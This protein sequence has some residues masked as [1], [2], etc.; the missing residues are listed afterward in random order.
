MQPLRLARTALRS[1]L[2]APYRPDRAV[3]ALGA[4]RSWGSTLAGAAAAAAALHPND[5]AVV[6]D[7]QATTFAELHDRTNALAH[8]LANRGVR[9]G[10]TV[11]V[12]AHNGHAFVETCIAISKLGADALLLNT[13]MAGP[14]LAAVCV[15]EQ[16]VALVHDDDFAELVDLHLAELVPLRIASGTI[17]R[18]VRA[19]TTAGLTPPERP[20]RTI[21][22]TSG[23]TGV[24]KGAARSGPPVSAGS[25]GLLDAVPYRRGE[26]MLVAAPLFHA[27]GFAHLSIGLAIG[28]PVVLQPRF[29]PAA[30][31]TEIARRRVGVLVAVPV[32]LRR[33]LDVDPDIAAPLDVSCLRLVPLSGSAIPAGLAEEFMDRFGEVVYNLYG[34][35]EVGSATVASPADLRAAPGTAGR[36]TEGVS[37]RII[38]DFDVVVG[39]GGSGRIF[40]RGPLGFDGYTNGASRPVIDGHIGTG[41]VGHVDAAGR[42][43]VEGR[44]DDMIVSGGEN[45]SP[46][47]VEDLLSLHP[48][49]S[50]VAVVGVP[51]AEFGARLRAFVVR[52]TNGAAAGPELDGDAVRWYVRDRLA[53][54]KVPRDVVFVDA[55]PRNAAGKV[56]RRE[57]DTA[58][59]ATTD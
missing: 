12:L 47:E 48:Q 17:G 40:V 39:T 19:H 26:A 11:A 22:L 25:L 32:M 6:A 49:I 14:Q 30:V 43:F 10:Q 16:A 29:D 3:R 13:A 4:V 28:A 52:R 56:L 24:P 57:L 38:D 34:S 53:R 20:G 15:A 46:R 54:Y 8:A 1:G 27:W 59:P 2:I 50:E 21:I 45:L 18:L 55:L 33:M 31:L 37:I 36:P 5:T 7:G 23:T 51:D 42:L 9:A 44:E 41:D 35:T 58:S